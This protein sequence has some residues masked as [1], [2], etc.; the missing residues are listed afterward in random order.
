MCLRSVS[1]AAIAI[2]AAVFTIAA[3]FTG[4]SRQVEA[5]DFA[6][7]GDAPPVV[8]P[9]PPLPPA[10]GDGF[11][12]GGNNEWNVETKG[13]PP[14]VTDVIQICRSAGLPAD[15]PEAPNFQWSLSGGGAWVLGFDTGRVQVVLCD[16]FDAG[17]GDVAQGE[18][19]PCYRVIVEFAASPWTYL[20]PSYQFLLGNGPED[21]S[22]G[23]PDG[24]N[25]SKFDFQRTAK[26]APEATY[27]AN[28]ILTDCSQPDG[29]E[30]LDHTHGALI[31]SLNLTGTLDEGPVQGNPAGQAVGG[32]AGL[33]HADD[34][35]PAT[36]SGSRNDNIGYVAAL[37]AVVGAAITAGGWYARRRGRS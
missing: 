6:L 33:I 8:L 19:E 34:R 24:S 22:G 7:P 9:E 16:N 14:T 28:V 21:G 31:Q 1:L 32:I 27:L 20:F 25:I 3:L 2:A 13:P 10:N 36:T 17:L 23:H 4:S 26:G 5:S 29:G 11:V 35:T 12:I 15:P 30:V 37:A 18:P